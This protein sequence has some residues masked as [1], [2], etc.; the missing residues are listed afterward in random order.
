MIKIDSNQ[1]DNQENKQFLLGH[2]IPTF[3]NGPLSYNYTL[4]HIVLHFG[5]ENGHGSEHRISGQQFTGEIQLIGYNSQLYANYSEAET[6]ANGLVA[7]AFLIQLCSFEHK[8]EN[9]MLKKIIG[10]IRSLMDKG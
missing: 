8:E 2:Q 10:T 4:D 9:I 3:N 7:L 6:N 5:V 1:E